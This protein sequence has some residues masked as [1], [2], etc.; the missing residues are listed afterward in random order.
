ML[1]AC[2]AIICM[3]SAPRQGCLHDVQEELRSAQEV[4]PS[5]EAQ[6]QEARQQAAAAQQAATAEAGAVG[7][8]EQL[9]A[10]TRMS[11][12]H[13]AL[14]QAR[15]K[16]LDAVREALALAEARVS[17]LQEE[18]QAAEGLSAKWQAQLG[19]QVA[20]HQQGMASAETRTLEL[21]RELGA[22]QEAGHSAQ[23]QLDAAR[24]HVAAAEG[25]TASA[26]AT[27]VDLR[28]KLAAAQEAGSS[29]QEL[30]EESSHRVRALE[31]EIADLQQ[32]QVGDPTL[33]WSFLDCHLLCI[34]SL[35]KAARQP[36]TKHISKEC[37]AC[38]CWGAAGYSALQA[39]V[40][41]LSQ[42]CR[43][44]RNAAAAGA[45][46]LQQK[47]R[48]L[49]HAERRVKGLRRQL[50]QK[51]ASASSL[52]VG[53][54]CRGRMCLS[55][56]LQHEAAAD[57]PASEAAAE[58]EACVCLWGLQIVHLAQCPPGPVS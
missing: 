13:A 29:A 28:E 15:R 26:E 14:A 48:D 11:A 56:C 33:Q 40:H 12:D 21:H 35:P 36:H 8:Q 37:S 10:R 18:V 51:H 16:E 34:P 44:L 9:Q 19:E 17:G 5:A 20:A 22:A 52:Q 38:M 25:A 46:E 55:G 3:C 6:L 4:G 50:E 53:G 30:R 27:I 24:R 58:A 45:G 54:V 32:Q 49:S 1:S 47:S 31:A 57:L 23:A 41:H 2:A 43:K 7:L 42:E 39:Q